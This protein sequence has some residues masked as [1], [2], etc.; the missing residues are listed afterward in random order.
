MEA[1]FKKADEIEVRYKKAKVFVD[2][3]TQSILAKAF[4]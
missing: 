1:L 3:L 2:K 4:R